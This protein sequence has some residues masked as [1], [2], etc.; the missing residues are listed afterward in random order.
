[1]TFFKGV[2]CI[3]IVDL[4]H[5][6]SLYEDENTFSIFSPELWIGSLGDITL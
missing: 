5:I 4:L 2:S 3:T 1:M 6:F